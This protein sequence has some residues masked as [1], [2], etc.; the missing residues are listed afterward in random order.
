[1]KRILICILMLSLLLP[2]TYIQKA[3]AQKNTIGEASYPNILRVAVREN[4]ISGVPDPRGR[5]NYVMNVNFDQYVKDVLPNEWMPSW[6]KE[7]LKAG[8]IA[9]KM[10]AWYHHLHPV[11]VSGYTFDVDNTVNFQVYRENTN[12]TETD[13]AFSSVKSLAYVKKDGE[14]F[15]L[16]Y[17]AGYPNNPNWQYRNAQK[18]AQWG[19]EYWARQ[20]RTY[21]QIL[22]FYYEGRSLQ[23]IP[24]K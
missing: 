6:G 17:R 5:I 4:N 8:A 15:E 9:V 12:Q 19:S 2:V 7:S 18:M 22:Q 24:G 10:F 20:G 23:Q 13:V 1:M 11:K 3:D 16:N 21:L 14:I